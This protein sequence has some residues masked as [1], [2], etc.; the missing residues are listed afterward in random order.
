MGPVLRSVLFAPGNEPRKLAKV[1]A[2]GADGVILDLE[3]AVPVADKA[4]ARAPVKAA[5][6]SLGHTLACVRVNAL[7]TGLTKAD[8]EGVMCPE[9]AAVVLPKVASAADVG[10]LVAMLDEAEAR[11]GVA[12]G[13]VRI[14]PLIESGAGVQ[15]ADEIARADGRILTLVFGSGDFTR[16]LEIPSVRPARDASALL[17]AR[18]KLVVDARAA[19][20]LR[21]VDGPYLAMRDPEGFEEDCRAALRLGFQ[22]KLCIHP[23]QVPI[24]NRVFS[25]DPAEVDFCRRVVE[26]FEVAEAGGSAAITVDGVFVDYPI[27]EK[28]ER[29]VRLAAL[30]AERDDAAAPGPPP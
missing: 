3:D 1:G 17:Y 19:G 29:I 25:P 23:A 8:V 16:D 28:A 13:T 10:A 27:A 26:A 30:L 2:A 7:E 18:G 24:A 20:R 6:P 9:L 4:A 15:R 11:H 21:P 14:L 5:L 12:G 22:G